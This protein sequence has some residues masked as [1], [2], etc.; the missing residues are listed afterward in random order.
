MHA[1][2]LREAVTKPINT[3]T[4]KPTTIKK[5]L[6]YLRKELRAERISYGE[7]A[8]LQ[9]LAPHIDPSDIELREAAGMPENPDTYIANDTGRTPSQSEE[10]IKELVKELRLLNVNADGGQRN[11]TPAALLITKAEGRGK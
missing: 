11:N 7:L 3:K 6:E 2:S 10:L 1:R 8:E 5:R 4:M 9:S